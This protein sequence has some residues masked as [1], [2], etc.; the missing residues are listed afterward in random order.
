MICLF[1]FKICIFLI[2]LGTVLLKTKEDLILNTQGGYLITLRSTSRIIKYISH[3]GTYVKRHN[4]LSTSFKFYVLLFKKNVH[5]ID[6]QV[7]KFKILNTLNLNTE[8]V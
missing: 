5:K 3:L 2:N 6:F 7:T 4:T 8:I 1:S